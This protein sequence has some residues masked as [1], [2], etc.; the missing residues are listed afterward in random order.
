MK[1]KGMTAILA[2]ALIA[3]A[4][5]PTL[6]VQPRVASAALTASES[7]SGHYF[8]A[9]K[10][11]GG[12]NPYHVGGYCTFTKS[13]LPALAVGSKIFY[14][15]PLAPSALDTDIAV[16]VRT[17]NTALG[18]C[19]WPFSN[20]TGTCILSGG[21]GCS[22]IST[23]RSLSR[24][25]RASPCCTPGRART[26]STGTTD[27]LCLGGHGGRTSLVRPSFIP[28]PGAAAGKGASM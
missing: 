27:R 25:W 21:T 28:D 10:D 26:A 22:G 7:D 15:Q 23:P 4:A 2:F 3:G 6:S 12:N 17:G 24:P 14:L 1:L 16:E 5:V 13:T 20:P 11:C 19:T 8:S 18:H 9:E